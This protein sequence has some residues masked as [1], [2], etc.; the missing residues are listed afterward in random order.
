ML[1]VVVESLS[2]G[3]LALLVAGIMLALIVLASML[4]RLL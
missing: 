3:R 2:P 4:W 1:D